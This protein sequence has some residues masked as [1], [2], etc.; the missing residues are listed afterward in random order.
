MIGKLISKICPIFMVPENNPVNEEKYLGDKKNNPSI[1]EIE[2]NK[3]IY[4]LIKF[5][6]E[7]VIIEKLCLIDFEGDTTYKA[8][9]LQQ[10]KQENLIYYIV[11]MGRHDG[12]SDIY[13]TKGLKIH[14][15]KYKSLLNKVTL[16]E[17][18]SMKVQFDVTEKG[19]D[20]YLSLRDKENR[21]IE[22]KIKENK[23]K[24]DSFGLIAPVGIMS[25]RPD[26]FPIIYLKK[27]NM[28]EQKHTDIFVKVDEKDLKPIKLFPLCNFKRVYLARYSYFNNIKELNNDYTGIIEPIEITTDVDEI[29]IDNCIYSIN[30]N[31]THPEIKCVKKIDSN[32]EIKITFSP[33]IPDIISLKDNTEI[34]G[35]FS[36]S[37]DEVKGI[38]GGIYLVK[39]NNDS[40]KLQ[41]NPQ[42][43]WQPM[44]GKLWMKTYLWNCD[45]KIVD[46]ILQVKS[47]WSRI[48]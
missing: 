31:N 12:E 7:Q 45:I 22:F 14:E 8:I 21:I 26:K 3:Y 27:F 38:M 33:P 39:K 25:D 19:I 35:H 47:K 34:L 20:A 36:L 23:K 9:E 28:V 32:S 40:I 41:I 5:K 29:N 11:L 44:P 43:G 16:Y 42:K 4:P 48:K 46:G 6:D 24:L 30:I 13:Y 17:V 10:V 2:K 18:D 15:D 1:Y 37:V